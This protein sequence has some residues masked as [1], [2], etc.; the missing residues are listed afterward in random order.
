MSFISC[1]DSE[2]SYNS[3]R[4]CLSI[5]NL[6][7][8]S[9]GG[10]A[11]LVVEGVDSRG[12]FFREYKIRVGI[13]SVPKGIADVVQRIL[14]NPQGYVTAIEESS[15]P[16]EDSYS[17]CSSKTTWENIPNAG[18]DLMMQSIK[19]EKELIDPISHDFSD[20]YR[21][22]N[23]IAHQLDIA[24]DIAEKNGLQRQQ[25]AK[26]KELDA[27]IVSSPMKFQLAGA[28]RA[29]SSGGNGAENCVNWVERHLN[30]AGIKTQRAFTD[31]VF[32]LPSVHA[33]QSKCVL[34]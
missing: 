13:L 34:L 1:V 2:K 11:A 9:C 10:C 21:E 3:D 30:E 14:R 31:L 15:E 25:E 20:I 6:P 28:K 33:N 17:S 29:S 27:I 22:I 8:G 7:C 16:P 24:T 19:K 23:N 4:W 18:V 5:I 32:S 12:K 26:I